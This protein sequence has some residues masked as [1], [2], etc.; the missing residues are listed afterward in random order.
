M[1]LFCCLFVAMSYAL[2]AGAQ[3][4]VFTDKGSF[5]AA[6]SSPTIIDFDSLPTSGLLAGT[7]FQTVGLSISHLQGQM[8]NVISAPPIGGGGFET[9]FSSL[10]NGISSSYAST[11]RPGYSAACCGVFF[12]NAHADEIRF[13]FVSGA[14]AA[15]IHIGENDFNGLSIRFLDF[16]GNVIHVLNVSP[17]NP[18]SGFL[19]ITSVTRIAAMEVLDPAF[20][21][22]GM[23][24]D[25]LVFQE[26]NTGTGS[27]VSTEPVVVLPD[28]TSAT[29]DVTFD[30]V[31][32]AGT[33]TVTAT[34]APTGG[35]PVAPPNFKVG[36]PAVYYD[37]STTATFTGD[38]TLCFSWQ[39]GQFHNE[40]AIKLFHYENNAWLNV[41]TSLDTNTNQVC[42]QVTSLSP[43]ALFETSYT[44]TG[45][46]QPIENSPT[47]NVI[48][49]GSAVPVRFSLGGDQGLAI[50]D[51][52]YPA[53]QLMQCDTTAPLSVIEETVTAGGSTLTYDPTSDRYGYIWKTDKS[54]ANSCR[55]LLLTFNDGTTK[56]VDFTFSR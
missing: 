56:M 34:S 54:W 20:D 37:V 33:T 3:V 8:I 27:N 9:L 38:V 2:P 47:R 15:G 12:S 50:F 30:S 28:G 18:H 48:K 43:L 39:E 19:G 14:S 25:D 16:D 51:A 22:D 21:G 7:E 5:A 49:A 11:A 4:T 46:F 31:A 6:L 55:R 23:F 45:F 42:G 10:P 29:I 26:A 41:T 36:Q 17:F 44:F 13:T 32:Q 40:N 53:S 52:G 1:R 24:F 35:T